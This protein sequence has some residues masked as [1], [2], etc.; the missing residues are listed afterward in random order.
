MTYSIIKTFDLESKSMY[1]VTDGVQLYEYTD[2]NGLSDETV[3]AKIDRAKQTRADLKQQILDK[4]EEI[5][6][7]TNG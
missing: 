6:A 2:E 5:E 1:R 4:Q 7:N 3:F